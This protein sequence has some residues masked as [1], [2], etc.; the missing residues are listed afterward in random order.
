MRFNEVICEGTTH[1]DVLEMIKRFLPIAVKELDLQS[2]PKMKP[3]VELTIG[4]HPSFGCFVPETNT[5]EFAINDRH[6]IDIL[7]TL[8]HELVHCKQREDQRLNHDS[9][10]TGSNEENEANAR[11]GIIMR[12][13][14]DAYPAHFS[15]SPLNL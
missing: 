9:G 2:L 11:A 4:Q 10:E 15:A 13:F 1:V 14:A 3:V 8:A 12:N 6:P 5:I 7:R